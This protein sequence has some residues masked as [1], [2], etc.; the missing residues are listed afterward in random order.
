MLMLLARGLQF[1]FSCVL[2][3]RATLGFLSEWWLFSRGKCSE[4]EIKR[5]REGEGEIARVREGKRERE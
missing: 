2:F 4:R 3:G 5:I 1:L